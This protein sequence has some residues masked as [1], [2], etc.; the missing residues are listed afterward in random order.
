MS[1]TTLYEHKPHG[2]TPLNINA[3][4][5]DIAGFNDRIA[6]LI[7]RAVSTMACAYIF[8]VLAIIGFPGWGATPTQWV[9]WIS[10]TFIQL[11]MLSILA[12]SQGQIGNHQ[13]LQADEQF[14]TTTKTYHEL[15]QSQLHLN[16]QDAALIAIQAEQERQGK[17]L[18]Q[19]IAG[20]H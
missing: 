19:L 11:V 8:A 7:T 18:A 4:K 15:E 5:R 9:Q 12:V 16:A 1:P 10:Q 13:Q 14:S 6:L 17:A 2:H 20:E 3:Y